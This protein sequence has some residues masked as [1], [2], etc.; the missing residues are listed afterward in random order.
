MKDQFIAFERFLLSIT[1]FTMFR[2]N[3]NC[4]VSTTLLYIQN[5]LASVFKPYSNCFQASNWLTDWLT[6]WVFFSP[7]KCLNS[8]KLKTRGHWPFDFMTG[9]FHVVSLECLLAL[10]KKK[11]HLLYSRKVCLCSF[12]FQDMSKCSQYLTIRPIARKGHGSIVHKAKANG[13]LICGP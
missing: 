11:I 9:Y 12:L 10:N 5:A 13:L 1:K 4:Q 2:Q 6:K 8:Q 7:F 3:V